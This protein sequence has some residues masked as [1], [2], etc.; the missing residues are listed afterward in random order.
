MCFP[1]W[2]DDDD[3]NDCPY[4]YAERDG[5]KCTSCCA[6]ARRYYLAVSGDYAGSS[7]HAG[8]W[9]AIVIL[10]LLGLFSVLIAFADV[11][12][13]G[14]CL[15]LLAGLICVGWVA[16][17]VPFAAVR[18]FCSTLD[19]EDVDCG[20]HV[21]RDC[22]NQDPLLGLEDLTNLEGPWLISWLVASLLVYA[23]S[24]VSL[25]TKALS[26]NKPI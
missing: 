18:A 10:S 6:A 12:K 7:T 9:I 13:G 24:A 2:S 4:D 15:G 8:F 1:S 23:M 25:F 14:S 26:T 16:V 17:A 21:T 11:K 19:I 3:D 20:L 22:L 5:P